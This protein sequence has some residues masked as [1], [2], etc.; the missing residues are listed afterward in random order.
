ML[1]IDFSVSFQLQSVIAA[2]ILQDPGVCLDGGVNISRAT[3]LTALWPCE[4]PFSNSFPANNRPTAR[5]WTSIFNRA[6]INI[7][8]IAEYLRYPQGDWTGDL[9]STMYLF[10]LEGLRKPIPSVFCGF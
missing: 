7:Q 10:N 8:A 2:G 5:G 1:F 4:R 9:S 3:T 6:V